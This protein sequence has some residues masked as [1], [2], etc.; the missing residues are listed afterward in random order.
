MKR[1]AAV[2]LMVTITGTNVHAA[3]IPGDTTP[4]PA[5]SI[6]IPANTISSDGAFI[7]FNAPN[8]PSGLGKYQIR[9]SKVGFTIRNFAT[10]TASTNQPQGT[11]GASEAINI[12]GLEPNTKYY[13]AVK[14]VDGCGNV[15]STVMSNVITFT[16]PPPPPTPVKPQVIISWNYM[17]ADNS[18][19]FTLY[20]FRA[21]YGNKSRTD[22]T[23]T[24]WPNYAEVSGL[25]NSSTIT[26][27]DMAAA[28]EATYYVVTAL[29]TVNATGEMKE[30]AESAEEVYVPWN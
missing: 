23:F 6:S 28:S 21:Y 4:P 16:T 20:G 5:V 25:T 11:P 10:A 24:G 7:F 30:S 27:S 14:P 18:P 2:A 22:P 13:V 8:D 3:C 15:S 12:P 29:Y 26:F 1:L 17:T 9:A 19:G